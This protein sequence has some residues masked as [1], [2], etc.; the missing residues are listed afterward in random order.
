MTKCQN[1]FDAATYV[2]IYIISKKPRFRQIKVAF[3]ECMNFTNHGFDIRWVFQ[4]QC[5][6]KNKIEPGKIQAKVANYVLDVEV[7]LDSNLVDFLV[8]EIL[9]Y[10][11]IEPVF[12]VLALF[13]RVLHNL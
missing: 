5:P 1:F 9:S 8:A 4:H 7:V 11:I 2:S 12:Q 6:G 10:V 13:W 3:S